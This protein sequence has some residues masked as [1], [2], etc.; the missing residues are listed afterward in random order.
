[1]PR[2]LSVKLSSWLF[3]AV[4]S[5]LMLALWLM[6]LAFSSNFERYLEEA[7]QLYHTRVAELLSDSYDE[8]GQSWSGL[9][10]RQ[11]RRALRRDQLR[12]KR[13]DPQLPELGPNGGRSFALAR[14]RGQRDFP[15][16]RLYDTTGQLVFGRESPLPEH[17]SIKSSIDL[18]DGTQA[19]LETR[20][21][22]VPTDGARLLRRQIQSAIVVAAAASVIALLMS[23][24]FTRTLLKPMRRIATN[25]QSLY[26]GDYKA[27]FSDPP[28][29]ELG[30]IMRD[31]DSLASRLESNRDARRRWFME[32][33]HELRT[34]LTALAGEVDTVKD[35]IRPLDAFQLQSFDHEI[36]R[37]KKLIDDLHEL[38]LADAGALRY[39]FVPLDI[40]AHLRDYAAEVRERLEDSGL[41]LE[42]DIGAD[43][44]VSGDASRLDQ[45]FQNLVSNANAYTDS[46]GTVLLSA[47]K[48]GEEVVLQC[49]D[50]SP[51]VASTEF[52][53]LFEPLYRGDES[54]SRRRGGAGL[55]LAICRKIVEAHSG[56]I[57]ADESP[58]GGLRVS[59]R[60]PAANS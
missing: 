6:Q 59:I 45:L 28:S 9:N 40:G 47:T 53:S 50:S 33:S 29:D 23:L 54:R 24:V 13:G 19:R 1:M 32:I 3:L 31:I 16:I 8:N 48:R 52:E 20:H 60:L 17:K 26:Q 39:E 2:S 30:Q 10:S 18:S 22:V 57:A 44:Y 43:L 41:T 27:R 25:V 35:G 56:T 42:T 36:Q 5:V 55:G 11:V 21:P 37:L 15:S 46:P 7:A 12:S 34:P 14:P 49:S 38:A 4:V 58:L 51:G